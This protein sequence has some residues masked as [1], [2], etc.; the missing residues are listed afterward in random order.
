[1]ITLIELPKELNG[2]TSREVLK[3]VVLFLTDYDLD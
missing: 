1:M 3:K 2:K